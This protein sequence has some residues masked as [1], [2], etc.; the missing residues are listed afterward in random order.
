[1]KNYTRAFLFFIV[2]GASLQS[3]H[4]QTHNE[5]VLIP[6]AFDPHNAIDADNRLHIAVGTLAGIYYAKYSSTGAEIVAPKFVTTSAGAQFPR[7]AIRGPNLIVVWRNVFSFGGDYIMGQQLTTEGDM[8]GNNITFSEDCCRNMQWPDV[9]FL[10][11]STYVVVWSGSGRLTPHSDGIY[12]QIATISGELIGSNLQFSDHVKPEVD[13]ATVRVLS[14]F[15]ADRFLV[16][17]QDDFQGSDRIFGRLIALDG[18]P[19]DSSFLISAGPD[20]EAA[21]SLDAAVDPR[22][23]FGVAWYALKDSVWQIRQR[24]FDENAMASGPST[25]VNSDGN[26]EGIFLPPEI[27]FD[28]NGNSI[29]V[30]PQLEDEIVR[31]FGQRFLQNGTG[32]GINFR[33]STHSPVA[34][35]FSASVILHD[36]NILTTWD[37]ARNLSQTHVDTWFKILDFDDLILSVSGEQPITP[38]DF[39]LLQNYPNPFNPTTRIRF[40]IGKQSRV[41]LVI[42]NTLGEKVQTLLNDEILPG[43]HEVVWNGKNAKGGDAASGLYFV[44][45]R[46]AG[47]QRIGKMVLVR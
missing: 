13:H 8:V 14:G 18:T 3:V 28:Q 47:L 26:I 21:R 37:E 45:L 42:Y 12:G 29:V 30:W 34:P 25:K 16:V 27:A 20:L 7:L 43:S 22:G 5:F 40:E 39:R 10:D 11:D 9:T 4:S 6:N 23:G 32:F 31:L 41:Q 19:E 35:Q 44:K 15:A 46:A 36:N 17:W 1:M 2:W 24:H 33:I 38:A